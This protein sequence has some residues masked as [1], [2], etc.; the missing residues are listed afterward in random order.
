MRFL[1][2]TTFQFQDDSKISGDARYAIL[3]HRWIQDGEGG[4]ISLTT[5][6][7]TELSDASLQTPSLNKLRGACAKA[8]E[9]GL[10]WIWIDTCCID[11]TSSSELAKA[12]NSMF[13]LYRQSAVCYIYLHDVVASASEEE[14]FRKFTHKRVKSSKYAEWF[15]RGW[16]LQELVASKNAQFYD[17]NWGYLGTK[18]SLAHDVRTLTGIDEDY[19]RGVKDIRTASIA[20]KM[21]W[22]ANRVT[23]E[24]EDRAYSMMGIFDVNLSLCYGEGGSRAFMRLQRELLEKF[25]VRTDESIFAWTTPTAGLPYSVPKGEWNADEWGLLAPSP[26]CFQ[27]QRQIAIDVG[28]IRPRINEGFKPTSQGLR[29]PMP[30][31]NFVFVGKNFAF[32]LNCWTTDT[33]GQL[34]RVQIHLHRNSTRSTVWKRVRCSELGLTSKA[35]GRSVSINRSPYSSVVPQ[36]EEDLDI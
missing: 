30:K 14:P 23:K 17:K 10:T 1:N 12:I 11:Q 33:K 26:E 22:M 25:T 27:K 34:K 36:P 3:S 29:L 24:P 16:T 4:E 2:T 19:L 5:L 31:N 8:K 18:D 32:I 6:N 7:A 9:Q 21:S 15:E 20:T 28:K 13:R 35:P